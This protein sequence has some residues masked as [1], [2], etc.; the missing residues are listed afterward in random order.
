MKLCNV[1]GERRGTVRRGGS[2]IFNS[3]TLH[4]LAKFKSTKWNDKCTKIMKKYVL[5]ERRG[6][7]R[8]GGSDIFNSL[9]LHELAKFK[10]TKWNDKCTKIMKK[11]QQ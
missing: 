2:D 8:R 10:S 4:E 1:Q 9:T 3:L 11:Y 7:V 6:T 5:G